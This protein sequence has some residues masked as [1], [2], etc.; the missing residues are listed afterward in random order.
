MLNNSL[1]VLK[2]VIN[3]MLEYKV[4]DKIDLAKAYIESA[5]IYFKQKEYELSENMSQDYITLVEELFKPNS[6]ELV[7]AYRELGFLYLNSVSGIDYVD[8]Q[9]NIQRKNDRLKKSNL[10]F[11]RALLIEENIYGTGSILPNSSRDMQAFVHYM[12]GDYTQAQL[13]MRESIS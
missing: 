7:N 3:L 6:A 8:I 11:K 2:Q 13:L 10:Y 5:R 4:K 9:S 12:L 1:D